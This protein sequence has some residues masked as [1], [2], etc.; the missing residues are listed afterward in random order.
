MAGEPT[1]APA[2]KVGALKLIMALAQSKERGKEVLEPHADRIAAMVPQFIDSH[3][4]EVLFILRSLGAKCAA[5]FPAL[6]AEC[7]Q[8]D[9]VQSNP[10]PRPNEL[11]ASFNAR[12]N[13]L[14]TMRALAHGNPDSLLRLV[15]LNPREVFFPL[16]EPAPDWTIGVDVK[17]MPLAA[18]V[19]IACEVVDLIRDRPWATQ[20]RENRHLLTALQSLVTPDREAFAR[21]MAVLHQLA[22]RDRYDLA[23]QM[24][25]VMKAWSPE[26][27]KQAR[28]E[29][30]SL[31]A[32][33]RRLV[34]P[35]VALQHNPYANHCSW[36]PEQIPLARADGESA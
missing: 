32:L 12:V 29:R 31:R 23:P 14:Q 16:F 28:A 2:A 19:T 25:D 11:S 18:R 26:Q 24:L 8:L 4:D 27:A 3:P 9:R 30:R 33:A 21:P 7:E 20:V 17:T 35:I 34:F 15:Q 10:D 36:I 1:T 13:L 22:V 5:A 6:V